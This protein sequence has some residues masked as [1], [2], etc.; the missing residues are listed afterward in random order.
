AQGILDANTV[1][2]GVQAAGSSG[3]TAVGTAG[4]NYVGILNVNGTAVLTVNSNLVLTS[5]AGGAGAYALQGILNI[6]GGTVLATNVTHNG[7]AAGTSTINLNRGTLDLQPDWAISPGRLA[8][9]TTVNIGAPG[10]TDPAWLLN[11]A[12]IST[13]NPLMIAS[14]GVL[15]G[16][17]VITSPRL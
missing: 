3:G 2:L 17:S 12:T 16:N 9:I 14:N 8:N 10:V 4:T 5:Q 6:D 11:A 15:S 13:P 1:Q 7:N